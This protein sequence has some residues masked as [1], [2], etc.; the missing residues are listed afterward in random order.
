VESELIISRS[1]YSTIMDLQKLQSNAI[2]VPTP[3]QT[4]QEY[5]AKYLD[6][7]KICF[8]QKQKKFNLKKAINVNKEYSGF[9]TNI[10]EKKLN[11]WDNIFC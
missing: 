1:G 8:Y 7:R 11:F 9:R 5:L 3:G 10:S 4:E 2:F 6:E